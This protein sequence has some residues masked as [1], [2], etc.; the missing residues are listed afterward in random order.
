MDERV[1]HAI[2]FGAKILGTPYTWW[3][4]TSRD[5]EDIFYF[6][7]MPT[8]EKLEKYGVN[9][10]GLVCL[11]R[12]AAG[13]SVIK[14][15]DRDRGGVGWWHSYFKNRGFLMEFDDTVD[16]PVGTLF[17]REYRNTD[18]QGHLAIYYSK[19]N[20][21]TKE[22]KVLYGTI[23]HAYADSSDCGQVGLSRMG[24]SH[25]WNGSSGYYEHAI[26]PEN[27]LV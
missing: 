17:L 18:D 12:H 22:S 15:D 19:S 1:L 27:W 11:M 16:Y 20:T 21:K 6:D 14:S 10:A 26:L 4:G 3:T 8:R 25:F 5:R 9:C 13:A 24:T 23:I 7:G 2:E